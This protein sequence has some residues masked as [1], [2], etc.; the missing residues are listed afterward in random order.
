M[1]NTR[2]AARLLTFNAADFSRFTGFESH[3]VKAKKR[4]MLLP[5]ASA[6]RL[7][8][9]RVLILEKPLR[10]TGTPLEPETCRW[11]TTIFRPG[12]RCT[13]PL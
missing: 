2:H 9:L 4:E 6:S 7:P 10:Y 13:Y 8:E 11:F 12:P 5:R 1:R 3:P